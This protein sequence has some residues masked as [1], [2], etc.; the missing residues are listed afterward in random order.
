MPLD[1][2]EVTKTLDPKAFTLRSAPARLKE[3]D[4]WAGFE[5]AAKPL[6]GKAKR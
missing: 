4:P 6:P 5:A 3:A 2:S 1:W